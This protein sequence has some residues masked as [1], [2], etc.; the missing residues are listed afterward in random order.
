[1]SGLL[2]IL[3]LQNSEGSIA[4]QGVWLSQ[5]NVVCVELNC[6]TEKTLVAHHGCRLPSL[7]EGKQSHRCYAV[8][9]PFF[10]LVILL[11]VAGLHCLLEAGWEP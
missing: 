1:L 4:T 8:T 2:M 9:S 3:S 11:S 10:L 5:S 6:L 7:A